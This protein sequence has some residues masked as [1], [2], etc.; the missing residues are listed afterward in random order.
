MPEA[1]F[2]PILFF[3]SDKKADLSRAIQWL[4]VSYSVQFNQR[5]QRSGHL[6][7]GQFKSLLI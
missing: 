6:F 2:D 3:G 1:I 7:Q 4:E 5:Y